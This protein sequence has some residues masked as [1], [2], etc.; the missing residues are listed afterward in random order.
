MTLVLFLAGCI[1]CHA[2]W[3]DR[4][5]DLFSPK[6]GDCDDENPNINPGAEE[7]W[8]NGVDENCDGN[9]GDQDGDGFVPDHYVEEFPDWM[10]W[11]EHLG[12]GDCWDDP[13][14]IPSFIPVALSIDAFEVHPDAHD[15]PKDGADQDCDGSSDYDEDGDGHDCPDGNP[16][17]TDCDDADPEVH[18][19]AEEVCNGKDDDCDGTIDLDA[20]DCTVF[21]ADADGDGL[22]LGFDSLCL[23]EPDGD[24]TA[25]E[26]G[27]CDDNDP[28]IYS[29]A[30][31]IC[32]GRDNDCDGDIDEDA[33]D[34]STWYTD[35]D[36]DGVGDASVLACEQPSDAVDIGGD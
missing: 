9:D 20:S 19:D 17:G 25:E 10:E 16:D 12:P 11:P 18:P 1:G 13:T 32:D 7:D 5:G 3:R 36:G 24:Y 14:M 6:D 31:E 35:G 33:I 21:Y 4:D 30:D 29:G 15:I 26:P 34:A 28:T 8:Y 23:C 22:G 27:D 2:D